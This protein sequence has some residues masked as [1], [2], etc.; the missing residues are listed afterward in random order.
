MVFDGLSINLSGNI[1]GSGCDVLFGTRK[2]DL[3]MHSK[4]A[5]MIS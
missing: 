3:T 5:K 2:N 4:G 1:M